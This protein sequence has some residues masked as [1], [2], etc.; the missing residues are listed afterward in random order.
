MWVW[1]LIVL[2]I[3]AGRFV[4]SPLRL[5]PLALLPLGYRQLRLR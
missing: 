3:Y 1:L 5:A 4:G 2:L